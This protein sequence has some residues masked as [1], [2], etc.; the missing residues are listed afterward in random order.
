MPAVVNGLGESVPVLKI[1]RCRDEVDDFITESIIKSL[2]KEVS[3]RVVFGHA[4]TI[5]Q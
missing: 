5:G 3:E 2:P 4:G 1:S